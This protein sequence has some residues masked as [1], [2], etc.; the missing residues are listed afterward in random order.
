MYTSVL[1]SLSHPH[2]SRYCA[3]DRRGWRI[4][5]TYMCVCVSRD[6]VIPPIN[7]H[8]PEVNARRRPVKHALVQQARLY[9]FPPSSFHPLPHALS[10]SMSNRFFRERERERVKCTQVRGIY[11]ISDVRTLTR[12][13]ERESE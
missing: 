13:G 6:D 12:A 3:A 9:I 7:K 8:L 10:L 2:P 11:R 1:F 5:C 4:L